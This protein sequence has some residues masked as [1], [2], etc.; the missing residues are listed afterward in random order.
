[1]MLQQIHG[2]V[3]GLI[4]LDMEE[5]AAHL[6]SQILALLAAQPSHSRSCSLAGGISSGAPLLGGPW[7]AL[8][9][10]LVSPAGT[11]HRA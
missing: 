4:A 3:S 11:A 8:M 5:F 10:G 6:S 9:R 2:L 1:M 7:M